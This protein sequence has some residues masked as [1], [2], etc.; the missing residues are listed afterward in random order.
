MYRV[1]YI[2]DTGFRVA[3]SGPGRKE[4]APR[5]CLESKDRWEQTDRLG[6]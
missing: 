1:H 6:P 3:V 5:R 2:Y 4:S